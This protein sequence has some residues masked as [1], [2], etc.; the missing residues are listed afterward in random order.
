[1]KRRKILIQF[2]LLSVVLISCVSQ[3][4]AMIIG[5]GDKFIRVSTKNPRYFETTN[6]HPW[7]P[8]MINF[9]LPNGEEDEVFQK[10]ESYFRHFSENGGNAMRIWI[11]S[12]FL[13]IEDKTQ[14]EYNPVKFKRIDKLLGLAQTYNIRI[15]FTLQH[16]RSIAPNGNGVTSWSNS[17]V[18]S[19]KSGGT[20]DNIKQYINSTEGRKNYLDRARALSAK[21]KNSKQIFSWEL[22]NEMDAVD[23][24]DWYSFSKE[25]LV[26]VQES[27]FQ[28]F[29]CTNIGEYAL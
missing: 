1:M 6:G 18:L 20:F 4:K 24:E 10:V 16:I 22:W 8:V 7:I 26:S 5:T 25:I 21:Y 17:P 3:S 15:K 14:G 12:P 19:N 9:I 23:V 11:S 27:V 2:L 13:E 28:S 29:G